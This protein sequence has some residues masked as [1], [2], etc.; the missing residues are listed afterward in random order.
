[1]GV[2]DSRTQPAT[3][4]AF[5]SKDE[6]RRRLPF[7]RERLLRSTDRA[8]GNVLDDTY[9]LTGFKQKAVAYVENKGEVSADDLVDYMIRIAVENTDVD[10]PDWKY[11]AARL[12]LNQLY[13]QASR[14]RF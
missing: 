10:A 2:L 7:V 9:D 6:R 12:Y 4:S 11:F 1:M 5:V 14:N 13:K 3:S 8:A